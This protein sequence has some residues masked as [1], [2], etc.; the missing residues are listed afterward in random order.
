MW[1]RRERVVWPSWAGAGWAG[2]SRC[3]E[4]TVI[5]PAGQTGTPSATSPA[6]PER[7]SSSDREI[8]KTLKLN[9]K[10]QMKSFTGS[11]GHLAVVM[12]ARLGAALRTSY[13]DAPQRSHP[14]ARAASPASHC[15]QDECQRLRVPVPTGFCLCLRGR[16]AAA[17]TG[18]DG[19]KGPPLDGHRSQQRRLAGRL[20][21]RLAPPAGCLRA[22]RRLNM[23]LPTEACLC[24]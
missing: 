23:V 9:M 10:T 21:P 7:V 1:Q 17:F 24:P 3:E 16:A 12:S 11:L 2:G 5:S 6:H 14:P 20:Q 19:G 13:R 18:E 22:M 15:H 4:F 8:G